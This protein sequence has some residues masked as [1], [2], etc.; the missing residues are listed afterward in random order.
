MMKNKP[1]L[2][3]SSIYILTMLIGLTVG[4]DLDH[5]IN[6]EKTIQPV[7]ANPEDA[8]TGVNIMGYILA[9]TL[10]L[11]VLIKKG[12]KRIL[13]LVV[14][15]G[16]TMGSYLALS[17]F[18]G[19]N[20]FYAVILLLL[21]LKKGNRLLFTNLM[22]VLAVSGIGG[23]LGASLDY[24]PTL[25]L[26]ILISA[27]DFISV[28]I[29][30]HMVTLAKAVD[31]GIPLMVAVPAGK[32]TLGLGT[33]DLVMPLTFCITVM[34]KFGIV[35][36]LATMGG[37]LIGLLSLYYISNK[38]KKVVLPA[39]PPIALGLIITLLVIQAGKLLLK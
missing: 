14:Y 20:A 38:K 11:H 36:S 39:M 9:A 25:I 10:V 22:L 19:P 6:V 8:K 27:Y 12:F 4:V 3:L 15:S 28:F 7:V 26:L 16:L 18:I 21:A 33:G 31:K 5:K 30:K 29:T 17:V 35:S 2:A 37:G 34:K 23:I 32:K 1:L 24:K 13:K